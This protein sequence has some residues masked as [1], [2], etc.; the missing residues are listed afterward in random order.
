MSA[1]SRSLPVLTLALTLGASQL[2]AQ[3]PVHET[4]PASP[5]GKVTVSNIAGR[6]TVTGGG[7]S[8][9]T[10]DGTLGRGVER[11]AIEQSG[12]DTRIE[13]K[14]PR[15]GHDVGDTNLT[16]TLPAGNHVAVE[17]VSADIAVADVDGEVELQSVSGGC[18]VS[19]RPATLDVETVSGE[20]ESDASA[21]SL[22]IKTVSGS[23]KVGG[24]ARRVHVETVSGGA[25]VTT[26]GVEEL[27]L[28][29]VSSDLAFRGGLSAG[30]EVQAKTFSGTLEL[31][32]PRA[33][34]GSLRAT[35]FSGDIDNGLGQGTVEVERHGPGKT[36]ELQLGKGGGRVEAETFS[37]D[38]KLR[39]VD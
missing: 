38:L 22:R 25:T 8:S 14:Y 6:V 4:R 10:V 32:L 13:V 19:G 31:A 11:L 12:S 28:E 39:W 17:T 36:F 34:A 29:A 20:V 15:N 23:A 26:D 24:S 27:H 18:R 30:G 2:L 3:T 7:G 35:S 9:I 37:G 16:I 1:S 5:A 33:L 21:D